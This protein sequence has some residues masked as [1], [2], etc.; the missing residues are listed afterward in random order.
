MLAGF[1]EGH[2]CVGVGERTL[3]RLGEVHDCE[4]V[5]EHGNGGERVVALS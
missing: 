2:G 5:R 4:G 3:A 1:G